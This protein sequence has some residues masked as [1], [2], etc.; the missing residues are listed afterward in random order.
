MQPGLI[1][2]RPATKKMLQFLVSDLGFP[3]DVAAFSSVR[4]RTRCLSVCWTSDVALVRSTDTVNYTVGKIALFFSIGGQAFALM[5]MWKHN[6][7]DS[8][9]GCAVWEQTDN[10]TLCDL[11][12]LLMP[13]TWA[14]TQRGFAKTLI[15]YEFRGLTAMP[16]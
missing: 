9:N 2:E 10:P 16:S 13:V 15:P 4:A 14:E 6:S 7:T 11:D 1:E 12:D 3:Q 8:E 5:D